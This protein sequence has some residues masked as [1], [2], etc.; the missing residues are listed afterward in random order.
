MRYECDHLLLLGCA[1]FRRFFENQLGR[2]TK[3]FING[4][5]KRI[6]IACHR[7]VGKYFVLVCHVPTALLDFDLSLI[8]I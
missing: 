4:P 5:T 7:S 8:H 2:Q 1:R 3:V 6:G